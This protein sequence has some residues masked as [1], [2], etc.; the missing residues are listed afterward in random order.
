MAKNYT[1]ISKCRKHSNLR[2]VHDEKLL[3]KLGK[4]NLRKSICKDNKSIN[5]VK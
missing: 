1:I 2:S 3:S 4:N 5:G